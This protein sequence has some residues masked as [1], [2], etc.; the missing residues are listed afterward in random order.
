MTTLYL[1]A[2]I[3][4]L[5]SI[6]GGLYQIS[7]GPTP[8]DRILVIQLLGTGAV[9]V[10]ILIGESMDDPA[11]VDVALI[12]ALLAAITMVAFVQRAWTVDDDD[13]RRD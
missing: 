3:A 12:L 2:A 7:R 11:F 8:G 9:A 1:I 10:L 6:S 13:E 5:I 4:L